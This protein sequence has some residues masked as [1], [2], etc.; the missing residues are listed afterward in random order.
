[1][2]RATKACTLCCNIAAKRVERQCYACYH[3][4]VDI[5]W[6][7]GGA[8]GQFPRNVYKVAKACCREERVV[9]FFNNYCKTGLLVVGGKLV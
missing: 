2:K 3:P 9:L 6:L 7:R 4:S 5:P 8:G 1:M